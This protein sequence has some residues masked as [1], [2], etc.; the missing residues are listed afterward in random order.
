MNYQYHVAISFAGENRAFAEA[1]AEGLRLNGLEVFYDEFHPEELWGEELPVKLGKI[2]SDESQFC[3]MILTKHYLEK[4]WTHVERQNAIHRQIKQKGQAYI[5]PIRLDG[6][7]GD[8]PGLPSTIGYLS[9]RSNQPDNVVEAFLKKIGLPVSSE[10]QKKLGKSQTP[11]YIPKIKKTFT[12]KEKNLFLRATYDEI[13]TLLDQFAKDTHVQYPHIEHEIEK[14]TSRKT[15][16]TIYDRGKQITQFKVWIG[17]LT[18]SD[19]ISILHGNRMD[20]ENDSSINESLSIEEH[21]DE[22]R[23]KPMGIPMFGN[24]RN[25]AMTPAESAEYIWKMVCESFLR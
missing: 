13:T 19:S 6:F 7:P 17:G 10:I 8:V 23:L 4:M 20:I 15:L 18:G 9:F 1:V 25:K 3:I 14:I 5:L 11:S 22:L 24:D 12:D 16:F 2:Y 21:D